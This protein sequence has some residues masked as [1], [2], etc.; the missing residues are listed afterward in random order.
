M[1]AILS[2][3]VVTTIVSGSAFAQELA[4]ASAVVGTPRSIVIVTFSQPVDTTGPQHDTANIRLLRAPGI[5]VQRVTQ[6]PLARMTL[7]LTLSAD[8]R[9][10]RLVLR[11]VDG[12]RGEVRS[13]QLD[14]RPRSLAGDVEVPRRVL[15]GLDHQPA[16][17]RHLIESALQGKRFTD[18]LLTATDHELAFGGL[19]WTLRR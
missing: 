18:V 2:F 16:A 17:I 4:I 11:S 19:G 10:V 15:D 12:L 6:N 9:S 3:L 7:R 5:T 14:D 1:K 13:P 8:G